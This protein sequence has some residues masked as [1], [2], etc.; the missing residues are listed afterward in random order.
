VYDEALTA[1]D[2][3]NH[4]NAE[5][6]YF[7]T[8]V[9]IQYDRAAGTAT[10]TWTPVPGRTYAVEATGSLPA[11]SWDTLATGLTTGTYTDTE[12]GIQRFYRVREE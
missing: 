8:R 11:G 9:A 1:E 2:I 3:L 5:D 4:F 12:A 7:E 6:P 10:I